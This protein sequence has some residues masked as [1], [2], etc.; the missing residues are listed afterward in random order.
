MIV[1]ADRVMKMKEKNSFLQWHEVFFFFLKWHL[2]KLE[3][4]YIKIGE[5]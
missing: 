5:I 3:I 1:P 2:C 4:L